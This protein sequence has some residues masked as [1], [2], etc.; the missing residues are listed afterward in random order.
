MKFD[1]KPRF[2]HDCPKCHYLGSMLLRFCDAD[3]VDW[4][5]CEEAGGTIVARYGNKGPDYWSRP[6]HMKFPTVCRLVSTG[7]Y[8]VDSMSVL[9]TFMEFSIPAKEVD[10]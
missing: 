1:M 10:Q 6:L 8:V 3:I 5:R 7:E 2:T 9:S 4:Y